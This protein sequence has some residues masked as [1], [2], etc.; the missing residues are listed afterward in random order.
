M[1]TLELK[2]FNDFEDIRMYYT[3][4]FL[5]FIDDQGNKKPCY[6]ESLVT[7]SES[8]DEDEDEDE[9]KIPF[10]MVE[11]LR[12]TVLQTSEVPFEKLIPYPPYCG[13]LG[14]SVAY[15]RYIPTESNKYKKG[16]LEYNCQITNY[17]TPS[18]KNILSCLSYE[19]HTDVRKIDNEIY[20]KGLVVQNK[21]LKKCLNLMKIS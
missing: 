10:F 11:Y 2:D 15:L 20:Y 9:I 3:G 21:R 6:V 17:I 4:C 5:G 8:Y 13:Y 1:R 12:G 18:T 19:K 14:D 7:N 16:Y